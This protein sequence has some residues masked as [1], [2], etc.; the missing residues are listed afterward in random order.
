MEYL[1]RLLQER[2]NGQISL[3]IYPSSQLGAERELVESVQMNTVDIALVTSPLA[4][5]D[6]DWY[7]FDIPSIFYTKEHAYE[8]LD[9]E[10]GQKMLDGLQDIN[11][12]GVSFWETGFFNIFDNLKAIRTPQ[13]LEGLTMR[14]MEN[15]AY[16][17]YFSAL[18]A[19]PVP[20]AYSEVFTGIQN[21]TVNGT[22]IPIAA[23][24]MNQFYTVVPCITRCQ[25]WYC[26]VTFIMSMDAWNS[27]PAD[28]QKVFQECANEA[29]DY[30]R[31]ELTDTEE[32]QVTAMKEA[33]CIFPVDCVTESYLKGKVKRPYTAVYP[34]FDTEYVCTI[35]MDLSSLEP[36]MAAPSIPSNVAP[37]SRYTGRRIDQVI[38]GCCTNG[39]IS[40]LRRAA[41]IMRERTVAPHVRCIIIPATQEIYLQAMS[42]GL[43]EQFVRVGAT[44]SMPTCGPCNGGH[45]GVLSDGE[46]CVSTTNRNFVGRMGAKSSEV[47]LAGPEVAAACAVRGSIVSPGE[48]F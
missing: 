9:G 29:R 21:G 30:M 14:V 45:I 1:N 18:G 16:I 4:N 17:T 27:L 44:I 25:N 19:N 20:M 40:D 39:H 38:I 42:E 26:P 8:F 36:M 5:F 43:L 22:L 12:K 23:I 37:V 48:V 6:T 3:D 31:Q 10:Y 34:D 47:Y 11:I 28:L 13:D 15:D 7:L 46:R 2:T 35:D 41:E 24:Y 32:E 33:G